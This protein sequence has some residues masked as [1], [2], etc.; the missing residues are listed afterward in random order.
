MSEKIVK[1]MIVEVYKTGR[2]G[3]CT[4]GGIS[5]KFDTLTLVG[6]GVPEIFEP[7]DN[8]PIVYLKDHMGAYIAVPQETFDGK[9]H[10]MFGG[11]FLW[12]SDSRFRQNISEAPL[13][14]HD[15]VE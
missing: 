13:R 6:E 8:A 10:S 15:R 12:T 9:Q 11:S 14:I 2:L 3:D 4:N 1:G 5:S 7:S